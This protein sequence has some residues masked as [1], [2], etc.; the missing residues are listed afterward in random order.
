MTT[1]KGESDE[2]VFSTNQL[3]D[4]RKFRTETMSIIITVLL[5]T[6]PHCRLAL[7]ADC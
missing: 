5:T 3:S 4:A 6:R 7:T 1:K 2:N